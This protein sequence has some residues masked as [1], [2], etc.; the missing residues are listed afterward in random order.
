MAVIQQYGTGAK[1]LR[2]REGKTGFLLA[3]SLL[4]AVASLLFC[5]AVDAL[6]FS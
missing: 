2:A 1:R 6:W 5:I 4:R 3:V